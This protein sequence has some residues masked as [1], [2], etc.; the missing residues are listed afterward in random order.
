MT[1]QSS[2]RLYST[3]WNRREKT[4]HLSYVGTGRKMKRSLLWNPG[5]SVVIRHP[6]GREWSISFKQKEPLKSIQTYPLLSHAADRVWLEKQKRTGILL[7]KLSRCWNLGITELLFSCQGIFPRMAPDAK[8]GNC[9]FLALGPS[10]SLTVLPRRQ[11]AAVSQVKGPITPPSPYLKNFS[12][13]S[14]LQEDQDRSLG[15]R[16]FTH[17]PDMMW[18]LP[19]QEAWSSSWLIPMLS[20]VKDTVLF[21]EAFPG[22]TRALPIL[23][24]KP[25]DTAFVLCW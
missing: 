7:R 23:S 4:Q 11:E 9:Y 14:R 10:K 13:S 16:P 25:Q 8:R 24:K 20:K 5:F 1:V 12:R 2:R 21:F 19:V 17:S 15:F 6:N 18:D 22:T 3:L